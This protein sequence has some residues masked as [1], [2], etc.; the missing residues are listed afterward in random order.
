[1]CKCRKCKAKDRLPVKY[2]GTIQRLK[3]V[4]P[5]YDAS[6]EGIK[7]FE[8]RTDDPVRRY[9]TGDIIHLYEWDNITHVIGRNHYKQVTY[10]LRDAPYVP[11]GYV[12]LACMPVSEQMV[13]DA[14]EK[15]I[16]KQTEGTNNEKLKIQRRTLQGLC[17]TVCWKR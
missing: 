8:I 4:Q 16:L 3:T 15:Q 12:C 17:A 6:E 13:K 1:M 14:L 5:Y 11:E 9:A 7:T 2:S 10:A